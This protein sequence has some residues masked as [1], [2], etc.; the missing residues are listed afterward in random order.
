MYTL[1]VYTCTCSD[2]EFSTSSASFAN[3]AVFTSQFLKLANQISKLAKRESTYYKHSLRLLK[4]T[5]I[6]V[7]HSWKKNYS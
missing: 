6:K 7:Y 5:E 4:E 2:I 3:Y 1:N